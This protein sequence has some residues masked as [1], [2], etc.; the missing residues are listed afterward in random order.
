MVSLV[1]VFCGVFFFL[2]IFLS[3]F[4]LRKSSAGVKIN[5]CE[6]R[7]IQVPEKRLSL[8]ESTLITDPGYK[9]WLLYLDDSLIWVTSQHSRFIHEYQVREARSCRSYILN[10]SVFSKILHP[11]LYILLLQKSICASHGYKLSRVPVVLTIPHLYSLMS[12]LS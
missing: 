8:N 9:S 11:D 2:I 7:R 3:K 6:P 10:H 5:A 1:F 4:Q 12:V